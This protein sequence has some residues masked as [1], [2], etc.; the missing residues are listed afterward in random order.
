MSH[1]LN[2]WGMWKSLKVLA[3]L[4]PILFDPMDWS[5]PAR[6][7]CSW[8]FPSKNTGVGCHSLLQGI[9]LTQG[10][11]L[12]LLHCR[13]ILYYLIHQGSPHLGH[14]YRKKMSCYWSEEMTCYLSLQYMKMLLWIADNSLFTQNPNVTEHPVFFF[15]ILYFIRSP[16]LPPRGLWVHLPGRTI[17]A[18][19]LMCPDASKSHMGRY[20][21]WLRNMCGGKKLYQTLLLLGWV[22]SRMTSVL[23]ELIVLAEQRKSHQE[24]K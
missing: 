9:F 20:H 22:N 17:S 15:N 2:I 21:L 7:L 10:L 11:N 24:I 18:H 16:L 1:I 4:C 8:D 12:G 23:K 5:L 14:S 3:Q 19:L 13:W 6:L